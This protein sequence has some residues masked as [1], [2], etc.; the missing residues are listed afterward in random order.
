LISLGLNLWSVKAL[1]FLE[2]SK[3][4]CDM[5]DVEP[6]REQPTAIVIGAGFGGMSVAG[7]LARAGYSVTCLEKHATPGGRCAE[8]I[9]DGHRFDVGPTIILV[10]SAFREAFSALDDDLD[11]QCE[12]IKVN[13][14]YTIHF[15]D[16]T[17]IELTNDL[18][19]MEQQ[20]CT[21]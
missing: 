3:G 2:L 15:H 11:A 14:T 5:D 1:I 12:L 21:L 9:R 18:Q 4:M 19:R 20:V 10:P 7:R 13:P 17:S 16:G 6:G 8:I